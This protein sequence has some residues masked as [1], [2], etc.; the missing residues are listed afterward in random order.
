VQSR[1]G[2]KLEP[3]KLPMEIFVVDRA[4]KMPTEN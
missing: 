4:E 1:L 2:L 3:K